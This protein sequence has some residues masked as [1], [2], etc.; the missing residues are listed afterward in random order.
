MKEVVID[1]LETPLKFMLA[2]G[3]CSEDD[4]ESLL[5]FGLVLRICMEFKE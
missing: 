3:L 5:R 1:E 2:L 4:L